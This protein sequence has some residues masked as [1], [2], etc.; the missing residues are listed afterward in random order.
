MIIVIVLAVS[1]WILG[2][3]LLIALVGIS[4]AFI[5]FAVGWIIWFLRAMG[6][7]HSTPM[8]K[9]QK[10]LAET[11]VPV[12]GKEFLRRHEERLARENEV[13]QCNTYTM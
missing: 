4:L 1:E 3:M 10:D 8:T 5:A 7:W 11:H 13:I 9:F 2:A 12:G 6:M